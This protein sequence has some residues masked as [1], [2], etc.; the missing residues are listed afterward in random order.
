MPKTVKQRQKYPFPCLNALNQII[1]FLN[2][3]IRTIPYLNT[4]SR[5]IPYLNTLSRTIPYLNTLNQTITYFNTLNPIL[6]HG[7]QSNSSRQPI[8]SE[9]YVTRELSARVEVPC[10]LSARVGSLQ[11]ILIHRDLNPP[12][13]DLLTTLLL[14]SLAVF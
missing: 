10:R 4:L 6:I 1:P 14:T 11:P 5:T 13:S 7:S 9:N 2:T 3:L 8:R 12:L